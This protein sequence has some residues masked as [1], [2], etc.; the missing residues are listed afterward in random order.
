[1]DRVSRVEYQPRLVT[2]SSI[3]RRRVEWCWRDRAA[4]RSLTILAGTPG[5]GKS[6]LTAQLAGDLTIGMLPGVHHGTP[7]SVI[8]MSLEDDRAAVIRPRLEAVK[9]NLD[10]VHFLDVEIANSEDIASFNLADHLDVLADAVWQ[11][12]PALVVIDPVS[13]VLGNVDSHKDA[14]VR[15]ILAPL[16][17]LSEDANTSILVVAHTNKAVTGDAIRRLGGSIAFSGAPRNALLLGRNPNNTES[18]SLRLLAHFKSNT[19]R[20]APTLEYEVRSV[21]LPAEDGQP[22]AETAR[23]ELVGE[24]AMTS[25][26]L[27]A[28]VDGDERSQT[29]E[30]AD[31]LVAELADGPRAAKDVEKIAA[32]H[33]VGQ[34]ALRRARARLRIVSERSGFGPGGSW[35]WALPAPIDAP[36]TPLMPLQMEGHLCD[37]RASMGAD[38]AFT[39]L[40]KLLEQVPTPDAVDL[41]QRAERLDSGAPEFAAL[42]IEAENLGRWQQ[43]GA[44][45]L[46]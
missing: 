4:T 46:A 44:E 25:N 8:F 14:A 34:K 30:A 12:R 20:L 39:R 21:L 27:L 36:V 45:N 31:L 24:S 2:A 28:M 15:G 17:R 11:V 42:L 22:E 13:A 7:R 10:L 19:G 18:D 33:G 37:S 29:D 41:W 9:A 35:Q 32:G 23:L 1:M 6:L 40:A 43:L 3:K 5:E 26:D 16:A 38:A